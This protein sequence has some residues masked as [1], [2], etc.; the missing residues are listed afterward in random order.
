MI[1]N[2][3]GSETINN[4]IKY[5]NN[6]IKSGNSEGLL[7]VTGLSDIFGGIFLLGLY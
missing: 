3:E 4:Y 6:Y 1:R 5:I 7:G 2:G